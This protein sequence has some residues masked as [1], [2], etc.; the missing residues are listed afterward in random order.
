MGEKK[1]TDDGRSEYDKVRVGS[2]VYYVKDFIYVTPDEEGADL[3]TVRIES[4]IDTGHGSAGNRK[5][6]NVRWL[7]RPS[8]LAL[9]HKDAPEDSFESCA[10]NEVFYTDTTTEIST[11]CI[12]G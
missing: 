9:E 8:Q 6:M 1:V 5:Q 4:L 10:P 7:W 11:D 12:E 3:D 2:V